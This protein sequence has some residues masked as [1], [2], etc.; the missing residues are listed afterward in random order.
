MA[1]WER[2]WWRNR[3]DYDHRPVVFRDDGTIALGGAG[4]EPYWPIRDARLMDFQP[5]D[6]VVDMAI[7]LS[8]FSRSLCI[9]ICA[10]RFLHDGLGQVLPE[11]VAS[12][13]FLKTPGVNSACAF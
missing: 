3:V 2:P 13:T 12:A 4:C 11:V 10:G 5:C 1:A 6:L 9:G 7:L 8:A